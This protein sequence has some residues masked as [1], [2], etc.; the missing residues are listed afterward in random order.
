MDVVNDVYSI[1]SEIVRRFPD[2]TTHECN[3]AMQKAEF[4]TDEDFVYTIPETPK[5][6]EKSGL[7][8]IISEDFGYI[9]PDYW[10][11]KQLGVP[12]LIYKPKHSEKRE[13]NY[14]NSLRMHN[15][16]IPGFYSVSFKLE[17]LKKW[18]LDQTD[19]KLGTIQN[20]AIKVPNGWKWFDKTK[21]AYQFGTM[22]IF[23]K[24]RGEISTIFREAMDLFEESPQGIS[25]TAWS[26]RTG[27]DKDVLR[28]RIQEINKGL[29]KLEIRF[30][31]SHKGYYRIESITNN[32]E[33]DR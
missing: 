31:S 3:I 13:V 7:A 15:I 30:V 10:T 19:T 2:R 8:E 12:S 11:Y 4:M 6:L 27:I 16:T 33:S 32:S 5:F 29:K 9:S 25:I 14:R 1:A 18:Y 24:N 22:G 23:A 26:Q 17:E 21:G 20:N 28:R